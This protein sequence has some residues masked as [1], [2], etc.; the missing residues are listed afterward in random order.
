MNGR[1][2]RFPFPCFLL[3]IRGREWE[4]HGAASLAKDGG[5]AMRSLSRFSVIGMGLN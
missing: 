1:I 3:Q 4:L 5:M 2:K